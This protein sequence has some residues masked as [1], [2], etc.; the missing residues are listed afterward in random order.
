MLEPVNN[1]INQL[2]AAVLASSKYC[3]ICP[4]I[5]ERIG[6]AELSK[7]YSFKEAVKA[8]KN[9]LHQIGGAYLD[10]QPAYEEWEIRLKELE[11]SKDRNAWR[12][13]CKSMMQF[14]SSTRERLE[15][16]DHFYS[17][18]LEGIPRV[19]KVLDLACGLHPLG[20]PWMNLPEGV[21]YTAGD[22][23]S[24]MMDF[25]SHFMHYFPVHA[26]CLATDVL[27]HDFSQEYD[28]VYLL[29]SVPCLEQIDKNAGAWLLENV[30]ASH[31]IVSFPAH[32]LGG[33]SKGMVMNYEKRFTQLLTGK[34][35]KVRRYEFPSELVFRISR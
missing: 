31:I 15:S 16:I 5:I 23:Y 34:P 30:T 28:L 35:W 24:D 22:I 11:N 33:R 1:S 3:N 6:S 25:L 29:K 32:S 7:R 18:I 14:H 26:T 19:D 10:S 21:E 12:S 13:A 2:I 27:N 17:Q 9:K 20:M 8:T 4:E